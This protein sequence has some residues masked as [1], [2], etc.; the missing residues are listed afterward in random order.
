MAR[1]MYFRKLRLEEYTGPSSLY[2]SQY[3]PE[4]SHSRNK[5][6]VNLGRS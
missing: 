2:L 5:I 1:G 3:S 6:S 4:V